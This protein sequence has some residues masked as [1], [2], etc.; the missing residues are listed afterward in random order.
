MYCREVVQNKKVDV[1]KT[2]QESRRDGLL[3]PLPI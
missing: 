1:A 2:N 3:D